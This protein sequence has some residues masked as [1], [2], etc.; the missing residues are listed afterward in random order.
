MVS[1]SPI[2]KDLVPGQLSKWFM[3]SFVGIPMVPPTLETKAN[4]LS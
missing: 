2:A 1:H 4:L 3:P